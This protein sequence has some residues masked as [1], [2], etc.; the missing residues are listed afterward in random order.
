MEKGSLAKKEEF[1]KKH[2]NFNKIKWQEIALLFV[3]L[4]VFLVQIG[5]SLQ[6]SNLSYESYFHINRAKDI[7]EQ[8]GVE[9]QNYYFD[10]SALPIVDYFLAFFGLFFS[11]LISVKIINALLIS[12]CVVII[13]FFVKE[14]TKDKNIAL[15]CSIFS[16][17]IPV[18]F[19]EFTNTFNSS[20]FAIVI[21]LITLFFFIKSMNKF[22]FIRYFIISLII[23]I[24]I[25][26]LSIIFIANFII[27][28]LLLNAEKIRIR[29]SEIEIF[30]FS[31]IFGIWLYIIL[32][33]QIII[34]QGFISF[35]K[36]IFVRNL[37]VSPLINFV[38]I[39]SLI[40]II[41]LL[42]GVFGVYQIIIKKSDR[43]LLFMGSFVITLIVFL[44]SN[45]IDQRIVL[46][47]L[48]FSLIIC[49]SIAFT[50]FKET[51]KLIKIKWVYKLLISILIALFIITSI[52][53]SVSNAIISAHNI[54]DNND[55]TALIWAKDNIDDNEIII[56]TIEESYVISFFSNNKNP[57]QTLK[58][59]DSEHKEKV[60]SVIDS[61]MYVE[62]IRILSLENI[63]YVYL[64]HSKLKEMDELE[65]KKFE[66]DC[67]EEVYS[68]K[69]RIFKKLCIIAEE[70]ELYKEIFDSDDVE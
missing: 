5:I 63:N 39:I 8:K 20:L 19:K 2:K 28:F 45:I 38:F 36:P 14:F 23:L 34:S 7:L 10:N 31:M 35:L 67:F 25:S 58:D 29:L 66:E 17:F 32:Y 12:L 53:P 42:L 6:V 61:K 70:E 51:S 54:P 27:Y 40:G 65:L 50:K 22:I 47:L 16:G 59:L 21:Y 1:I 52:I 4:V 15:L 37:M 69:S 33:K 30:L 18:F 56:G 60:F 13:Y 41:P 9:M 46:S 11:L 48:S 62:S 64:S 68:D 26:P 3:F 24:F 49:S 43:N 57:L 55:I 44:I